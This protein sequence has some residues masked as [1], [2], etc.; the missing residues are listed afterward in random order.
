MKNIVIVVIMVIGCISLSSCAVY[1]VRGM[2]LIRMDK[3]YD[4]FKRRNGDY[5]VIPR[6][7]RYKPYVIK[8][9]NRYWGNDDI[10]YRR[11]HR[12]R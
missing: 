1:D 4:V 2:D 5:Y 6:D 11:N 10:Y 8:R 3:R 7:R 9:D 12:I